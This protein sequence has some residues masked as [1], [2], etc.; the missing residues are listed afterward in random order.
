MSELLHHVDVVVTSLERSLPFYRELLRRLGRDGE[1]TIEGERGERV[2]YLDGGL[3]LR[4]R[5]SGGDVDRYTLG[6]HH[7]AFDA[8]SRAVVDDVAA[9]AAD[10]ESGPG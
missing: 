8:S 9:W 1:S 3:G 5:Q 7:L 2:H 6:L 4:E 10:V